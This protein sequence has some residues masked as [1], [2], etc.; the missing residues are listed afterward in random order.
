[1]G[2]LNAVYP[3]NRLPSV[4]VQL[5]ELAGWDFLY[6]NYPQACI[7]RYGPISLTLGGGSLVHLEPVVGIDVAKNK[8]DISLLGPDNT[9]WGKTFTIRHSYPELCRF[10]IYLGEVEKKFNCKPVLVCEATGHYHR[11]LFHFFSHKGFKVVVLNPIQSA[12]V[13][14][15]SIRKIKTDEVD[16]LR[17]AYIYRLKKFEPALFV[18]HV[19][20]GFSNA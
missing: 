12:C 17:L 7:H 18:C 4:L 16:S 10:L 15:L 13:K 19:E 14:N 3:S 2:L 5:N 8:S 20:E 6:P 9:Q 1:M 11:I